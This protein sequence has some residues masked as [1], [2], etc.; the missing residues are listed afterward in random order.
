MFFTIF[1]PTYNRQ[2]YLKILYHSL[3][4]QSFKDFEWLII[5]DGST[6][7]TELEITS[8]IDENKIKIRYH[9][10]VNGGK[11]RAINK[12]TD[13][14]VGKYFFIVDSD[15]YLP[16]DSLSIIKTKIDILKNN[17]VIGVVGLRQSN[18]GIYLG[19]KF[20]KDDMVLNHI[21]RSYD[22]KLKGDYAE[23]TRTDIIK[24]FKFPD[25]KQ[26]KFCAESLIWNRIANSNY[27]FLCFNKVVYS[28]EYLEEGLT[29]NSIN[30]RRKNNRY[31]SL[32][33]DELSKS[34]ISMIQKVRANIN[35]LRFVS[36]ERIRINSFIRFFCLPLGL[37]IKCRDYLIK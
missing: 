4:N 27:R 36:F 32:L 28:G 1:T 10:Q 2:E 22:L 12:A 19:D 16:N 3:I 6:D 9:K 37:F 31:A 13:L 8:F 20:P 7:N 29:K 23:V 24:K 21:E 14:A 30:N 18:K 17:N 33:Y 34:K 11:H 15:D 35:Y 5:D 25:F 26:E